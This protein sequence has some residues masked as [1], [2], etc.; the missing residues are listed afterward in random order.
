MSPPSPFIIGSTT[1]RTAAVA[2][3]ASTALPPSARILNPACV[4]SGEL[5]ATIPPEAKTDERR[6]KTSPLS[7]APIS[8]APHHRST[9][10]AFLH[11]QQVA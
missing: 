5:V 7:V 2:S 1:P 4:A 11:D 6:S 3:A 10:F 8:A 9:E